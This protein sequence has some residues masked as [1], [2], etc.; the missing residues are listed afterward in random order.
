[1]ATQRKR[2]VA[3]SA[4]TM[5]ADRYQVIRELDPTPV[6][7]VWSGRDMVLN[8]SV[9]IQTLVPSLASNAGARRAFERACARAGRVTHPALLQVYDIG[10]DNP[11]FVVFEHPVGRR[12]SERLARGPLSP[13]EGAR[14]ALSLARA[15]EALHDRGGA[16]GWITPDT[17]LVDDEGRPKLVAI[18]VADGARNLSELGSQLTPPPGYRTP[19][20][21]PLPGD[22]DRFALA[23]LTYHMLTGRAPGRPPPRA[24]SVRRSVPLSV[25]R[26]LTNAL[27]HIPSRRPTF[28][29]FE[30]ALAPL[31][32]VE[33]PRVR[34]R[35]FVRSDLRWIL[36]VLLIVG[37]G[38]AA[39]VLGPKITIDLQSGGTKTSPPPATSRPLEGVTADDFDP[40]GSNRQENPKLV[41]NATDGDP[42][43]AWRTVQYSTADLGG[44]KPGVGILFD[45]GADHSVTRIRV[46]STLPGW[47]AE[48]R[49][50]DSAGESPDDYRTVKSFT[51]AETLVVRMP[52][53]TRGRYF[54]LWITRL[55]PDE[56]AREGPYRAFVNEVQ[57]FAS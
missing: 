6:G 40:F 39:V 8:R 16:H 20:S 56:E 37:L 28:D 14:I 45:L 43:T 54:L 41:G 32:R 25:E 1:M 10:A 9:S 15:L 42:V 30:R 21:K 26:L 46:L 49:V 24:R 27:D 12:L 29:E 55:A 51:A 38:I 3:L 35:P 22:A 19:E 47:E 33:P 4:G 11:P 5:L 17:V 36:P 48:W 7:P 57:F 31:A 34:Q 44:G 2:A 13:E 53:G 52:S 18:G 50:S 23:A